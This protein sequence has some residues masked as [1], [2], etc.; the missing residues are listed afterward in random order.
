MLDVVVV[1]GDVVEVLQLRRLL[2]LVAAI[3]AELAGLE[4]PLHLLRLR[5]E[6]CWHP[7]K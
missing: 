5:K 2:Q 6:V 1:A 7:G 3:F 4:Y